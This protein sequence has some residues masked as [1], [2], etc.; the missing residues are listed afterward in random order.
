M[1]DA[2]QTIKDR[3]SWRTFK[4]I[5]IEPE[6]MDVL[7]RAVNGIKK[8]PFG[9]QVRMELVD[10]EAVDADKAVKL[11]TY[12]TIEGA[13]IFI[14]AAAEK[15][16][17]S[18]ADVGYIL[19]EVILLCAS[20]GLGTCWMGVTYDKA[21]FSNAIALKENE[22]LIAVTPVGYAVE[23]RR[24][25]DKAMRVFVKS[26]TRKPLNAIY[27]EGDFK[28]SKDN[29]S[30]GRFSQALE[31]V[32]VAPS[33]SNQQPWRVLKEGNKFHFYLEF[34]SSYK[35]QF[36]Q[37]I[38]IGIAMKHLELACNELGIK[39]KWEFAEPAVEHG[40]KKYYST[41]AC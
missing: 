30:S 1:K 20:L 2:I 14:A 36:G 13:K 17:K 25:K 40:D 34:T 15:K 6:K 41:Y 27:F 35:F 19:E 39:G 21:G 16:D 12:G 8:G 22:D 29:E 24:M 3:A 4:D 11:G 31:C 5:P 7:K 18:L 37:V 23:K 28:H 33:A 26:D 10:I 32:R 9:A 38:D